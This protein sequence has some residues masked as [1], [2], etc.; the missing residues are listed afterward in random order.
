MFLGFRV[1]GTGEGGG[2]V[3]AGNCKCGAEVS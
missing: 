1:D 2:Q 3:V